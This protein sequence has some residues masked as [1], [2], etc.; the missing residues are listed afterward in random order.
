[1]RVAL[2]VERFEPAGGG[3]EHA[4]WQIA[5]GLARAGDEVHVIARRG[6]DSRAATLHRVEVPS[7]W[8]PLR[9]A[10]FSQRAG[11]E[12]RREAHGFEIVH[13]F[14]RTVEQ[15]IFHAGGGSH[16]HYMKRAYGGLG[17][18]LRR[19]S[20]RH[21][22][23]LGLERRIFADQTQTVQC[24]SEMVRSE[25]AERFGVSPGR[26]TVIP[27]GVDL[28]RFQPGDPDKRGSDSEDL[29]QQLSAGD[30]TVWL[31]AGSGW[32]RKGL[33]T[34]LRALALSGDARAHLWIA[35]SDAPA[36]WQRLAGKLGVAARVH[37]LGA[38]R[39]IEVVY[40]A[41]DA[42]L[43]PT[44]YDAFGLVCLEASACGLPV[45]TSG[46]AG[47]AELVAKAGSVIADPED[48]QGFADAME[49]LSDA[50]LRRRLGEIG[51]EIAASNDWDAHV[52]KLRA[53]Y[54][55]V[56]T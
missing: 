8:Q 35:G 7:F 47:A 6:S 9:V 22:A 52:Q 51:V 45:V 49:R 13:S 54:R 39:D 48:V 37:F 4:V 26:M 33:D 3:I 18:T 12:A 50:S 42:L 41:A 40:R 29:R 10:R 1:M 55:K 16:A 24:V 32:R 28:D 53:L 38:R 20:P 15:D 44:R 17:A 56:A 25:I 2:V 43:L 46:A 27:Y 30:A 19:A 34:A 5:H 14:S 31:L 11:A 36:P 21:A 23:L